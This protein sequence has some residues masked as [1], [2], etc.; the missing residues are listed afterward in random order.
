MKAERYG[1]LGTLESMMFKAQAASQ[2]TPRDY[3]GFDFIGYDHSGTRNDPQGV[4]QLQRYFRAEGSIIFYSNSLKE[5]ETKTIGRTTFEA[6]LRQLERT[7][8]ET[9]ESWQYKSIINF[10]D[11]TLRDAKVQYLEMRRIQKQ[12]EQSLENPRMFRE[13]RGRLAKNPVINGVTYTVDWAWTQE[14]M[15]EDY[16]FHFYMKGDEWVINDGSQ[17]IVIN[18]YFSDPRIVVHGKFAGDVRRPQNFSTELDEQ[19]KVNLT[20]LA[21][22]LCPEIKE[23][24]FP[25]GD[26]RSVE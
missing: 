22:Q 19:T 13:S 3:T 9:E 20:A 10:D 7:I 12:I 23:V 25:N 14:Q 15:S 17:Q 21:K 11:S 16:P 2:H 18:R 1:A 4:L 8:A 6:Q 26:K 24:L 5:P